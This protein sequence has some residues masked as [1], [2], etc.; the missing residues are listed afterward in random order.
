MVY[1]DDLLVVGTK[2]RITHKKKE[3]AKIFEMHNLGE[4]HWFL[5]MEITHD[6]IAWMITIDQWQY[7]QKILEHFR[8]ENVWSVVSGITVSWGL[9][10]CYTS[11]SPGE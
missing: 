3:V 9:E 11:L 6:Q 5:A 10:L 7:V 8:L 2:E 4:V 1:I